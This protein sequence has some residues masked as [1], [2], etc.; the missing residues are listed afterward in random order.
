MGA[1]LLGGLAFLLRYTLKSPRKQRLPDAMSP[2]IFATKVF[3]GSNGEMLYHV[4]GSGAPIIFVHSIFVGASSYE[5]SRVYPSFAHHFTV[6]ALDLVGF[7]ESARPARAFTNDDHVQLLTE[8]IRTKCGTKKPVLIG[9]GLGGGICA[10]L[11]SQHPEL[12]SRLILLMPTG[13]TD[14]GR[15]RLSRRASILAR[16]P[17]FNRLAYRNY[18]SRPTLI[19]AWLERYGFSNP[20]LIDAEMLDVISTCAQQY[21]AEHAIRALLAGK[22]NLDLEDR[23]RSIP[24]PIHFIWGERAV[25]P[26]VE[27]A[28]P[29]VEIC[30]SARLTTI[31][32]AGTFAALECPGALIRILHADLIPDLRVVEEAK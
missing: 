13:L 24:H 15:Q 4:S 1:G 27:W 14:F 20:E 11:A 31:E 6:Y 9:S 28:E 26:P 7:G 25:F 8:F 21:G 29:Y 3:E 22:L 16:L 10:Q 30:A 2:A 32:N 23:L 18:L 12:I 19:Q 17:V 5:W